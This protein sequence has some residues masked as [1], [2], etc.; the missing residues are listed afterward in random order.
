M[1]LIP[2]LYG[3]FCYPALVNCSPPTAPTHTPAGN[4]K[5]ALIKYL[6]IALAL[7]KLPQMDVRTTQVDQG[8]TCEDSQACY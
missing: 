4:I 8:I 7:H 3:V 5:P 1:Q 6:Q 2:L